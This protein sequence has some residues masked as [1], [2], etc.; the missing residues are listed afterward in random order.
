MTASGGWPARKPRTGTPAS[1][2]FPM[3][4]GDASGSL[5]AGAVPFE[6]AQR[7]GCESPHVAVVERLSPLRTVQAVCC[8]GVAAEP[9][10]V[11]FDALA[12]DG[13]D[14]AGAVGA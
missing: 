14:D 4:S 2:R 8:L 11:E 13:D 10:Q 12:V 9:G 3:S 5:K 7:G 1:C 6:Q